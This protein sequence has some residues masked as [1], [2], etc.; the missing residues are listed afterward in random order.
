MSENGSPGEEL[1]PITKIGGEIDAL[2]AEN[3]ALKNRLDELAKTNNEFAQTNRKLLARLN[4]PEQEPENTAP[5]QGV[6]MMDVFKRH[7]GIIKE[8]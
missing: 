6:V 4:S 2:K 5:E 3:L 1:D 7:L 8:K